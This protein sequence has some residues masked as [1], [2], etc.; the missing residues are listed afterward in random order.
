MQGVW[1][2]DITCSLLEHMA[3]ET[4]GVDSSRLFSISN[5]TQSECSRIRY[6]GWRLRLVIC[7]TGQAPFSSGSS[8]GHSLSAGSG[9]SFVSSSLLE[10]SGWSGSNS[11]SWNKEC[12]NTIE[13]IHVEQWQDRPLRKARKIVK[14]PKIHPIV[15]CV[16]FIPYLVCT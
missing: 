3:C 8:T 12:E 2:S 6:E 1:W 4:V 11:S 16:L 14:S 9:T 10:L 15:K 5:F 7:Q 13:Q